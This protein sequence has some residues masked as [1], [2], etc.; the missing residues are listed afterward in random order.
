MRSYL[1]FQLYREQKLTPKTPPP[2]N[3][4]V[5]FFNLFLLFISFSIFVVTDIE[6]PLNLFLCSCNTSLSGLSVNS[7]LCLSQ[8]I[9]AVNKLS[10]RVSAPVSLF[11][12]RSFIGRYGSG[13]KS[14]RLAVGGL[15]VRSH[16]APDELVGA[17]PIAVG[18]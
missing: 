4:K 15:R 17:L 11:F 13:G 16:P 7:V 12:L 14:S 3:K 6:M 8:T 9:V 2:R 1:P 18:V 10:R 5:S